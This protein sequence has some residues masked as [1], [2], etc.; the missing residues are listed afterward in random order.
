MLPNTTVLCR[1]AQLLEE[2]RHWITREALDARIE[3]ALDGPLKLW[4]ELRVWEDSI[5]APPDNP[6][7]VTDPGH[8]Q[9]KQRQREEEDDLDEGVM[10][11]IKI[12]TVGLPYHKLKRATREQAQMLKELG[13]AELTERQQLKTNQ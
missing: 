8:Q 5:L 7:G 1:R 12:D 6:Q 11:N 10:V 13:A 3:E 2:S 4:S 9:Q